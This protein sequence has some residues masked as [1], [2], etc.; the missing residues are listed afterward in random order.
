[1][2]RKLAKVAQ[3]T[4]AVAMSAALLGSG[5]GTALADPAP[6][7]LGGGSGIVIDNEYECTL[8]TIGHDA[9]GR[10]VGLTAGHC[11]D[12]GAQVYA[13]AA[14]GYG[15]IGKFVYS[16][17]ALDYAVIEFQPGRVIPVNRIG[18]VT[19]TGLGAPPQFPMIVCKEGRTTGNTCGVAWGDVFATNYETWTQMCVVEGDS[20]APVVVGSTLVGMVNAYLAIACFGPEV[21]TNMDAIMADINARGGAGAGYH[22]I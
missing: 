2:I 6:P 7:V 20:G 16:N 13:E 8:T 12:P 14:R 21:G 4:F 10:L 15:V 3:A 9:A 11:G 18:N 1:M 5:A 17:H 19:I 22:P